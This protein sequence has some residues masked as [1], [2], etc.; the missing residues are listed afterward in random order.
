MNLPDLSL[1]ILYGRLGWAIVLATLACALWRRLVPQ[2]AQMS[3]VALATVLAVSLAA[4]ALP[5]ELSPAWW[6][7]L[8]F[9]YPSGLLVGC[10]LLRLAERWNGIRRSQAMPQALAGVLVVVGALLYIDAVGF[11]ARGFYYAG[12][13]AAAAPLFGIVAAL[14]CVLAIVRGHARGPAASLLGALA[15]FALLRLPTGNL[16]DAVID[17]LLW[18]WAVVALLAA[19]LRRTG[20]RASDRVAEPDPAPAPG[21]ALQPLATEQ[22]SSLK[23]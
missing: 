22:F 9:Q 10:C 14:G 20:R 6:L 11:L 5:G 16:W 19:A 17:P 23:E 7:G 21:P 12:F 4:M 3:R 2:S 1:Q 18:G 13:G 15:L 8:A